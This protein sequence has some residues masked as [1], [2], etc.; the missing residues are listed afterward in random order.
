MFEGTLASKIQ[1]RHMQPVTTKL[2]SGL[3]AKP[4]HIISWQVVQYSLSTKWASGADPPTRVPLVNEHY[5]AQ[6]LAWTKECCKWTI[7][8]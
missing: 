5:H 1:L 4:I 3:N 6:R 8:G 2:D 7:D